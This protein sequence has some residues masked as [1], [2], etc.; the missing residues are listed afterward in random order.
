MVFLFATKN[1]NFD[2][3]YIDSFRS[4]VDEMSGCAENNV[5]LSESNVCAD[6]LTNW[7]G[8]KNLGLAAPEKK[9][10]GKGF[11]Y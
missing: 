7:D 3:S 8:T 6:Q 5:F 11:V 10:D 1:A 2:Q 4:F 9:I